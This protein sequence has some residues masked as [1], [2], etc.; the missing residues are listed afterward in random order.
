MHLFCY[1]SKP[2][3]EVTLILE[4]IKRNHRY[5]FDDKFLISTGR[6]TA[7]IDAE[8]VSLY[9]LSPKS[10]FLVRY[11]D[12]NFVDLSGEVVAVLKKT[13]GE[14]EIVIIFED[15]KLM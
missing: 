14:K 15:E 5:L 6:E 2:M 4:E 1:S 12:K 8:M 11:N 3:N 9:G 13:F 10:L 7:K